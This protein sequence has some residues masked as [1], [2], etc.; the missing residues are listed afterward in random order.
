[1]VSWIP[2]G[3]WVRTGGVFKHVPQFF[4]AL[5]VLI[6]K[7]LVPVCTITW[8]RYRSGF[9]VFKKGIHSVAALV[10]PKACPDHLISSPVLGTHFLSSCS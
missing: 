1:M 10:G 9:L 4:K 5:V 3:P 6:F 7:E 2:I 8:I